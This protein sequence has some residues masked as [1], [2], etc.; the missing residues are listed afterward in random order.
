[1]PYGFDKEG[2][3]HPCSFPELAGFY[4]CFS[5]HV[6]RV[7]LTTFSDD[8][9]ISTVFLDT[10]SNLSGEILLFETLLPDGGTPRCATWEQAVREH[11]YYVAEHIFRLPADERMTSQIL[12]EKPV[13]KLEPGKSLPV[14]WHRLN[15]EIMPDKPVLSIYERLLED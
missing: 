11:Q 10:R 14:L 9:E 13:F 2:V 6:V 15:P 12:N 1:M 5:I 8:T 4:E 7:G 3:P